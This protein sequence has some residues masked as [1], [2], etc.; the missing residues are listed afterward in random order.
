MRKILTALFAIIFFAGNASFAEGEIWDYFGDQNV[1]G[2]KPVSDKEFEQALESKKKKKKRDKNI[3]KGE[4]FHQ[5]NETQF[6]KQAG[7]ELPVLCVPVCIKL[8]ENEILPVGHYQV[9]G[10]KKNGK[11]YLKF[12]QSHYLMAE[13]PAVETPDDFNQETVHFVDI[14]NNGENEIKIIFGSIDFNAYSVVDIAE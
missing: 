10:E 3:P 6:I 14:L 13:I 4:E 1:Y 8:S 7:E 9:A 12:Y 5:S 2:Q 11:P